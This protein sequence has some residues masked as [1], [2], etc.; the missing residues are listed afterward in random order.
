LWL[1]EVPRAYGEGGS[2]AIGARRVDAWEALYADFIAEAATGVHLMMVEG[3][4]RRNVRF[5]EA[6]QCG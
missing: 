5:E 6:G 4:R 3:P 2:N 1:T